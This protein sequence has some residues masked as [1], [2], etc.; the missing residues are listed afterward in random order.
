MTLQPLLDA[1]LSVQVHVGAVLVAFAVGTWLL[2]AS[3]KGTYR[4]RVWG[5]V[6]FGAMAVAALGSMFIHRR[7][8]D[9]RFFGLSPGHVMA[10]LVCFGL[11]RAIASARAGRVD[12]HRRWVKGLYFGALIVNG[13]ANVFVFSGITHDLFLAP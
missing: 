3:G 12:V 9:S 8:P 10:L 6:F 4:H 13:L 11:W 1:P 7:M 5:L 2:F